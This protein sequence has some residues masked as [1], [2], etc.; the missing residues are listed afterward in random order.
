MKFR[1]PDLESR[2]RAAYYR[3]PRDG[4]L[5]EIPS[6]TEILEHNGRTFVELS[7]SSRT[8]AWFQ[9]RADGALKR[10]QAVPS[11]IEVAS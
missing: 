9:V 2:A 10:L 4:E 3:Y 6:L 1:N 7:N 5:T 8:L 11:W